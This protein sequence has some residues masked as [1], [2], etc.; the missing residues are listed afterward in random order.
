M[1]NNIDRNT[2]SYTIEH[3][4]DHNITQS[5]DHYEPS[6][7]IHNYNYDSNHQSNTHVNMNSLSI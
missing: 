6:T 2:T 3:K 1:I 4:L 5:F 7:Y